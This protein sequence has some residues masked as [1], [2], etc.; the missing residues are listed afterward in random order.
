MLENEIAIYPRVILHPQISSELGIT[1]DSQKQNWLQRDADGLFYIDY[2]QPRM[3][4]D[5]TQFDDLIL[6]CHEDADRMFAEAGDR[7]KVLQKIN[8][9][10]GYIN[11][12]LC[13]L[14]RT[15]TD[16]S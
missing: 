6:K 11:S 7:I 2:L 14:K 15:N 10:L 5:R 9:H 1:D 12:K 8:W 3:L 4:K 13:L 16:E